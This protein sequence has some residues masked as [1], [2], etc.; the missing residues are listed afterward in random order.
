MGRKDTIVL[1]QFVERKG[2]KSTKTGKRGKGRMT[3]EI[4]ADPLIVDLDPESMGKGTAEAI[5]VEI[6]QDFAKIKKTVKPSTLR[7]RES[8]LRNPGSRWVKKRYSG[9][10]IGQLHPGKGLISN[11]Q[12][13]VDSGRL[14]EHLVVRWNK[15]SKAFVINVPA[16]RLNQADFG[17]R[18]WNEFLA[19]LVREVPAL[20]PGKVLRR[21]AVKDAIS[22]SMKDA[23]GTLEAS[24]A[25]KRKALRAMGIRSAFSIGRVV[26]G[27]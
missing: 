18:G 22:Q 8:A 19:D 26:L 21:G 15:A 20:N 14:S 5:K 16:N 3:I 12:W 27:G 9:G 11:D 4:I 2:R 1:N 13:G 6:E 25:S 23:I 24:I 10:R 17:T 7:K